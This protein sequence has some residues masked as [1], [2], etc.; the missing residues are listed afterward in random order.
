SIATA[1]T[2]VQRLGPVEFPHQKVHA[3][4]RKPRGKPVT[5]LPHKHGT[6]STS[7]RA[8]VHM[9][10]VDEGAP[11]AV[12]RSEYAHEPHEFLAL[13]GNTDGL[14]SWRIPQTSVP[15]APAFRKNVPVQI[16]VAEVTSVGPSPVLS[17]KISRTVPEVGVCRPICE[18]FRHDAACPRA[19]SEPLASTTLRRRYTP[20][21]SRPCGVHP[22]HLQKPDAA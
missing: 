15:H 6:D 18:C 10:V 3:F 13:N 4:L 11:L 20:T 7:M 14:V 1:Q 8:G 12:M 5:R 21:S 2:R 16:L 9:K 19:R 22:R 17:V